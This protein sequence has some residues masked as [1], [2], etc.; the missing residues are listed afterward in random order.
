[1]KTIW[2][3]LIVMGSGALAQSES[4]QLKG[5]WS[6]Q[7]KG[8]SNI[9]FNMDWTEKEGLILGT[10]RDN[11]YSDKG[12]VKGIV[13]ELGRLFIVTFSRETKG[14]RTLML[15]TSELKGKQGSTLIPVS[16]IFRDEKGKPIITASTEANLSAKIN[17]M[18][19]Q[20]QED[21]GCQVGFGSLAGF[22]GVYSGMLT[23]IDDVKNKCNLLAFNAT[24]LAFDENGEIGIILG[25]TSELV[26][27]PIHR[28]GRIF[29]DP[30]TTEVEVM[31]RTC[32]QLEGTGF[33]SDDCKRLV[34]SGMFTMR[35][36]KRHFRGTYSIT[37]EKNNESCSY[38]ISMDLV[39]Q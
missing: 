20:K 35:Q 12:V 26:A 34:L 36:D 6:G 9:D 13:G 22:C 5:A 16:G 15:A 14:V 25:E 39:A 29:S 27:T 1:M 2:L 19:A 8:E 38:S 4:Y 17:E 3:I 21:R 7:N 31:S 23:E 30:E 18:I 37:S 33:A 11:Y 32:R 10:Y 28:V 24:K